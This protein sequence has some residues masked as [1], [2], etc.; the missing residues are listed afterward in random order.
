MKRPPYFASVA[1]T[2]FRYS[3]MVLGAVTVTSTMA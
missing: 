2:R 3:S 1:G